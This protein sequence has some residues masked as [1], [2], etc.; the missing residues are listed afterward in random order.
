MAMVMICS[1][2]TGVSVSSLTEI[3]NRVYQC[4]EQCCGSRS[5]IRWLF[6]LWIRMIRDEQPGSY[7]PELRNQ[8][9]GVK[10][11][12]LMRIRDG[13]NSDPR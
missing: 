3:Y 4:Y 12:S 6:E 1:A 5:R 9:L 13:K 11:N 8:F 2:S 10:I 7:F